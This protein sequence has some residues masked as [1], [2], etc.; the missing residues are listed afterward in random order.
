MK[1][2]KA[3]N[4]HEARP[5]FKG[6]RKSWSEI[7]TIYTREDNGKIFVSKD[8]DGELIWWASTSEASY[9]R[10]TLKEAIEKARTLKDSG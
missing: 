9:P 5:E 1:W 8:V 6:F 2:E 3:I 4:R 7:G 10:K